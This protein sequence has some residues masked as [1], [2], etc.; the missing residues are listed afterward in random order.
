MAT[1]YGALDMIL[2]ACA[3][4]GIVKISVFALENGSN[5]NSQDE[6]GETA[7]IKATRIGHFQI[8][9]RLC[10]LLHTKD[11]KLWLAH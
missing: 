7:L 4:K 6:K 11:M 8:S 2:H 10:T 9:G 1:N 5:V 3:E